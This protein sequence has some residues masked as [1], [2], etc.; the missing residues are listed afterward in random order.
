METQIVYFDETGDDGNNTCSSNSF[1]LTS[2]YMPASSWTSNYNFIHDCRIRLYKEYGFHVRH[3]MHT[4]HLI[5]DKGE[6]RNYKW[7]PVERKN[8]VT[9]FCKA[10]AKMD[11]SSINVIIDKT[12][13]KNKNYPVLE[14][15]LTYNIQRID[16]D[17]KKQWNYIIITDSGRISPMRKTARAIR[18]YNPV[19]SQFNMGEYRNIPISNHIEDILEKDSKESYFIQ[20]CDYISYLIHLYYKTEIKKERLPGRVGQL[21]DNEYIK[22]AMDYLNKNGVFNL[23]ASPNKY[24]LVIYPTK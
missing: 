20:V 9:L 4:K 2:I 1:I 11:I 3:E 19:R 21:I 14:T 24:G 13:I 12:I 5:T 17:L 15:A 8:I 7:L 16:N 22:T 6:Y 23:K 18:V 10:I